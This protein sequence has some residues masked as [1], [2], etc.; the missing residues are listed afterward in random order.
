VN[1]ALHALIIEDHKLVA[2]LVEDCLKELGFTSF[3]FA[4]CHADAVAAALRNLPDLIIADDKLAEGTGLGA[5][6]VIRES[7]HIPV[8][9]ASAEPERIAKL[10]PG[11][12]TIS[13]PFSMD[14][15][16]TAVAAAMA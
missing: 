4:D 1:Q 15:F 11:A 13:K 5:V 10:E 12:I 7:R 14:Q 16:K 8:V 2:A 9:F 3:D 6:T